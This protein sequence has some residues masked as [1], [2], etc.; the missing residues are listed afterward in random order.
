[1]ERRSAALGARHRARANGS[2]RARAALARFGIDALAE[3]DATTLSGGE[4]RRLALARAFVVAPDRAAARRTLRRSRRGGPRGAG[5]GSRQLRFARPD[6]AVAIVTHDLRQALLLADRIAVLSAGALAQVGA[7]DEVLRRP[8]SAEVAALV[9]MSNWLPG[10]VQARDAAGLARGRGGARRDAAQRDG[11]RRRHRR[12]GGDP[13]RA[14]EDRRRSQRSE[15]ARRRDRRDA[16]LGRR[17]GGG[18]DR[19]ARAAAAHASARRARTRSDAEGRRR[20]LH[21]GAARGRARAAARPG[22]ANERGRRGHARSHDRVARR[23]RRRRRTRRERARRL[24][25][26]RRGG[27][28][29][30]RARRRGA[31]A[32]RARRDR[33]GARARRRSRRAALSRSSAAAAA[34]RGSTSTIAAQLEAKRAILRDALER[35]GGIEVP[36]IEFVASPQPYGYRGRARVLVQGGRVGFRKRRSHEVCA[37]TACPLLAPPLDAALARLA[38]HPPARRR[39]V[40]TGARQRRRGA[41]DGARRARAAAAIASRCAPRANRSRCRA[42]SSCRRTRCCSDAL[43]QTVLEAAGQ[44]GEVLELFAGAGFFTL[45]LARRFARV[46]AVESDAAAVV[47][48]VAQLR[49]GGIAPRARDRGARRS[50]ARCASHATGWRPTSSCSIRRA[51]ASGRARASGS[52]GFRRSASSTSRAIRR[53][54]RAICAC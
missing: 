36:P 50:R 47:D 22:A 39:R 18:V 19:L 43:A 15:H 49:G 23:G 28:S 33:G 7:R 6:I 37:I 2:E 45:G 38:A 20:R 4:A 44:G 1:M 26:V 9:G 27:R 25:A 13:A 3:R 54:S 12:V 5:A 14:R 21:R 31:R 16:R 35:I 29:T 41:R 48:L 46:A 53:R 52:R 30:A 10:R 40:G 32:L 34:A 51:A 17:A 42:A 8:A 11:V 24:R